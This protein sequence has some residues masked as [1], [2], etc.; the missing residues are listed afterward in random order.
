MPP[1]GT[2]GKHPSKSFHAMEIKGV[3][4]RGTGRYVLG[5]RRNDSYDARHS[6]TPFR[7]SIPQLR[8]HQG[9]DCLDALPGELE[10]AGSRRAVIFCGSTLARAGSPLDHVRNA[11]GNRLAGLVPGVRPD[12][13]LPDVQESVRELRRMEAD[14]IVAVGGG[15]ALT[16]ARAVNIL[17]A[18]RDDVHDLCTRFDQSGKLHS[19][20]LRAPKLPVIAIPTTPTTATVKAGSAVLD[21][22]NGKRLSLYDP[23]ARARAVFIHPALVQSAPR[24]LVVSASLNTLTLALE[25]LLSRRGD[26]LADAMLIHAVRILATWLPRVAVDDD[27]DARAE[28]MAASILCGHGSD[29]TGA[30]MAIPMGRAIATRFNVD[31]GISDAILLPHVIR[32]NAQ[33][34][35]RGLEKIVVAL[36]LRIGRGDASAFMV[37]HALDK[38][39]A[40][41]R[42]PRRLRDV[43][44]TRQALAELAAISFDDWYLQNN[45]RQITAAAQVEQVLEEAW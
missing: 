45:P 11:M 18:E 27:P 13:P 8:I 25:G 32:F 10:R 15:S 34:A 7:H 40:S 6:M 37:V 17:L 44:V 35:Q 2:R 42:L 24:Q 20:R 3:L 38:L 1:F 5:Q 19:P 4:P 28:L 14:A 22:V 33:A 41:L 31:T 26:P 36:D 29:Y 9:A 30:G 16:M 39:F 23:K 21:T 12:T 43:G